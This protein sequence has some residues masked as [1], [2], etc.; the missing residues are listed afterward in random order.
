MCGPRGKKRG[1][2]EGLEVTGKGRKREERGKARK[3]KEKKGCAR[4]RKFCP[5]YKSASI[6]SSLCL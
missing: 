6:M 5:N 2:G 3:G 4:D 1:E